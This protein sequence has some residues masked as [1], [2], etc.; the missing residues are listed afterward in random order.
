MRCLPVKFNSSISS[1]LAAFAAVAVK[2]LYISA[3][4]PPIAEHKLAVIGTD[5]DAAA[6][7]ECDTICG[8]A[9]AGRRI[10]L[11][12]TTFDERIPST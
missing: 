1:E 2:S 9:H 3:K 11:Q 6:V 10:E 12:N 4:L 8:A 5:A 7:V